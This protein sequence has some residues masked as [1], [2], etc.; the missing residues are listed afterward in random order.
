MPKMSLTCDLCG[1]EYTS[2]QRGKYHHFC[3]IEC[4]RKAGEMVA[5]SFDEDTRKRAGERITYYNKNVFNKG[6]YRERQANALRGS[7]AC[8]GYVKVNGIHEHRRIAEKKIGR[9]LEPDEIVHHMDGN[10][11]NNKPE[12]LIVMTQSEHIREHLRLGGGR[13]AQTVQTSRNS[14]LVSED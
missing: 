4:R 14:S 8:N 9:P 1:K 12:N 13:L 10:K 5:S 3:S 7:G 11:R 2:Y 6:E